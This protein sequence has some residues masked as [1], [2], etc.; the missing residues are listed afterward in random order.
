M[1]NIDKA[2]K[3]ACDIEPDGAIIEAMAYCAADI[4]SAL[5][6][7]TAAVAIA[8]GNDLDPAI[9]DASETAQGLAEAAADFGED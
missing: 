6:R 9:R 4:V 7:L 8:G 5:D 2:L 3:L 1:K